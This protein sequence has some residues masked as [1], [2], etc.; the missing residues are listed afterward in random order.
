MRYMNFVD[1]VSYKSIEKMVNAN[2]EMASVQTRK[3]ITIE[4]SDDSKS[5]S[6]IA[7]HALS[8]VC[9]CFVL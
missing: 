2:K 7:V 3:V 6:D 4:D 1:S 9:N 8:K 5:E